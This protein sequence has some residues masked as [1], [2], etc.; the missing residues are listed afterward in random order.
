MDQVR[1]APAIPTSAHRIL[2]PCPLNRCLIRPNRWGSVPDR[3]LRLVSFTKLS[4]INHFKN[5]NPLIFN[6]ILLYI[7]NHAALSINRTWF[8]YMNTLVAI[9]LFIGITSSTQPKWPVIH[10]V[11][12]GFSTFQTA[13]WSA[14]IH[15]PL[16]MDWKNF[17]AFCC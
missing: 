12:K 10:S 3:V 1:I 15:P 9:V 17:R 7:K 5:I 4:G 8:H 13:I 16:R 6:V 14:D 2:E 11:H